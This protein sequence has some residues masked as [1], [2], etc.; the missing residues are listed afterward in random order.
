MSTWQRIKYL[1]VVSKNDGRSIVPQFWKKPILH[2]NYSFN[3][4][5]LTTIY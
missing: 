5:F 3:L 4:R 1:S 2:L